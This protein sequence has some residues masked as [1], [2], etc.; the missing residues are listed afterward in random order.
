MQRRG[1]SGKV[2]KQRRH[3]APGMA[4][5][6]PVM[7]LDTSATLET[8]TA[9]TAPVA[10]PTP[11]SLVADQQSLISQERVIVGEGATYDSHRDTTAPR[12]D[13]KLVSARYSRS[14]SSMIPHPAKYMISTV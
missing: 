6:G 2:Q 1:D 10:A 4:T 9:V 5:N 3:V 8:T 11:W 13:G 7:L 14:S 12:L